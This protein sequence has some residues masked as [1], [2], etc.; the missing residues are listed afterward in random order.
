MLQ[1]FAVLCAGVVLGWLTRRFP[2]PRRVA[3]KAVTI[4]ILLLMLI[5]GTEVGGNP[6]IVNHFASIGLTAIALGIG[7][8]AGVLVA[9][10]LLWY[11]SFRHVAPARPDAAEAQQTAGGGSRFSLVILGTFALGV[12][13]GIWTPA[14]RWV[15]AWPLAFG[16]LY[17]LMLAVG[18]TI[19]SDTATLRNVVRQ[20][21]CSLLVP[22]ATIV[23]SLVGVSVVWALLQLLGTREMLWS[24]AL[25]VGAGQA[26]YSLSGVL[27]AELRGAE[28]GTIGLLANITR[29]MLTVVG[30]AWMAR[31]FS[32]LGPICSGGATAVDVSL[33]PIMRCCGPQYLAL[34]V[35]QG[36]VA[37]LSVPLLVPFFAGLAQ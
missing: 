6:W 8:I 31:H 23:G 29:E 5:L 25:A 2:H 17:L 27:L 28:I 4:A 22:V 10:K 14:A 36:V 30:A 32:P 18:I 24:D 13:V 15:A 34:A 26:Y 1:I 20:P 33:P 11:Y 16:A 3:A 37:D 19:G 9:A 35:L 12:G 7:A 21:K